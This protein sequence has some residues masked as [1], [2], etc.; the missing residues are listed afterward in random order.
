[1]DDV[2]DESLK[3][4]FYGGI[5]LEF[6]CAKVTSDGGLPAYRDLDDVFELFD[7]VSTGFSDSRMGRNVQHDMTNLLRK[8]NCN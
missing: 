4:G 2:K 3:V 7:S 1:M 8:S 5:K 6:H